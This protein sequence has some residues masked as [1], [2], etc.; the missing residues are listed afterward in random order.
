MSIGF[1]LIK[2]N[3]WEEFI[4][5]LFMFSKLAYAIL[6]MFNNPRYGVLYMFLCFIL[7]LT[8]HQPRY[9]GPSKMKGI[10]SSEQF[11][12]EVMGYD[13]SEIIIGLRA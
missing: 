12:D 4:A 10:S 8:L 13:E 7:W 11:Y 3:T 6:F 1:K 9:R 2:A 5:N